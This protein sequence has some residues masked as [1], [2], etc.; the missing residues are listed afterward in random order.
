MKKSSWFI[1]LV[2]I[3]FL[4]F[5]SC[6]QGDEK[7]ISEGVIEFDATVVDQS[8]PMAS[9]APSK[10][11][12]KFKDDKACAEMSAGM[13]LFSTSFISDPEKHTLTQLVKLLNKR[14]TLTQNQ[15]QIDRENNAYPVELTPTNET[16]LIAGYKCKKTHVKMKDDSGLEF[17]VFSTNELR[18]KD[19]NF[20]NP[21]FKIDGVLMEY[22]MKKF[23]L[24]MR[25][26][27]KSVRKEDIDDATF[28]IPADYKVIS[29]DEMNELFKGLQ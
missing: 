1:C 4:L 22:Q 25:F 16:K 19:P 24:E 28:E 3:T 9:L 10:L 7:N 20:C 29:Q 12:M 27:A 14:F 17:D 18:I 11:I 13:G 21:Y 26:T 5:A 2:S 23:D 15:Q 6:G 8:N